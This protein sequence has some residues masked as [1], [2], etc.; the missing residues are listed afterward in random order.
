[1]IKIQIPLQY[2]KEQ[3]ELENYCKKYLN[4]DITKLK[5]R[6]FIPNNQTLFITNKEK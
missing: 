3:E 5:T 4:T 2:E 1:M 6:F